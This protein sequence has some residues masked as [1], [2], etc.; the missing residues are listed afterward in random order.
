MQWWITD[1]GLNV[2]SVVSQANVSDF[3]VLAAVFRLKDSQ[4][5]VA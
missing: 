4:M 5:V 2:D 1:E 3:I